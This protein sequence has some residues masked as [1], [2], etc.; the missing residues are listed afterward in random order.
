MAPIKQ[1]G[2]RQRQ[3]PAEPEKLCRALQGRCRLRHVFKHVEAYDRIKNLVID[4][5]RRIPRSES[6]FIA[7]PASQPRRAT[8]SELSRHQILDPRQKAVSS[9]WS[10]T[11]WSISEDP[12]SARQKTVARTRLFSSQLGQIEELLPPVR[13][14]ADPHL[15]APTPESTELDVVITPGSCPGTRKFGV[16]HREL[17][18]VPCGSIFRM[19]NRR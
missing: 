19:R 13:G 4:D 11:N 12:T 15:D 6:L 8:R 16:W 14:E 5:N 18:R 9:R 17:E 10:C 3:R 7:P 2:N 1:Q